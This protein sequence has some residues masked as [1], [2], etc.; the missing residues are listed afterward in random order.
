MVGG[1]QAQVQVL[2]G[3]R[4]GLVPPGGHGPG[5]RQQT[6]SVGA[7]FGVDGHPQALGLDA[8]GTGC[9]ENRRRGNDK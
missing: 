9:R 1:Q 5:H 6:L 4:Q 3:H 7:G 2:V 8:E